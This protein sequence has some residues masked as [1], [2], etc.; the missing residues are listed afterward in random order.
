MTQ[1][2]EYRSNGIWLSK[3][4]EQASWGLTDQISSL[5]ED[6]RGI[7]IGV[8]WGMN[9]CMLLDA[10]PNITKL[11]G[12][13]PY[14]SYQDWDRPVTQESA[15][16]NYQQLEANLDLFGN[17]FELIKLK[18]T[19]A[20]DQLPDGFFD[21]VFIDGDHSFDAVLADI[22]N[23]HVKVRAGGLVAGHDVGLQGVNLAIQSFCRNNRIPLNKVNIVENHAWYFIKE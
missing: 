22:E 21:F 10:C 18:S 9:T 23:Y 6:I 12:V 20:K 8:A 2:K 15:D 3:M 5:G 16:Y 17:R 13:D 4:T 14:L 19:E 1:L 11:Y 7:E